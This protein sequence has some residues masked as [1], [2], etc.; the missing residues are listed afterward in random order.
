MSLHTVTQG[1][2][3]A[4]AVAPLSPRA[5]GHL[6]AADGRRK[7]L[8]LG[9]TRLPST[10]LPS[11][12]LLL[13]KPGLRKKLVTQSLR[14]WGGGEGAGVW[15]EN[16]PGPAFQLL[17]FAMAR[18]GMRGVGVKGGFWCHLWLRLVTEPPPCRAGDECPGGGRTSRTG[19]P[20]RSLSLR[21]KSVLRGPQRR[22]CRGILEEPRC[23][24]S[25]PGTHPRRW[26]IAC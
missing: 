9:A 12:R 15:L 13:S 5:C 26:I 16:V 24:K 6:Q 8:G 4:P 11:T 10:R 23:I 2:G 19:A 14:V 21:P 1:P 17:L 3:T 20:A 25:P 22:Q 7:S 18:Q